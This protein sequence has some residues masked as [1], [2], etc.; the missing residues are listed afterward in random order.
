M[1]LH[2]L[3]TVSSLCFQAVAEQ[4]AVLHGDIWSALFSS[5]SQQDEL[6]KSSVDYEPDDC[7]HTENEPLGQT[8]RLMKLM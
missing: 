8:Q 4:L 2:L 6:T 3:L 5:T 1:E 7:V